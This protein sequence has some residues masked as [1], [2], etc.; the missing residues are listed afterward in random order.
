MTTK[1]WMHRGAALLAL[2]AAAIAQAA[3]TVGT[4]FPA[5]FPVIEDA[6][7]GKPVIGFGAAGAVTR[8]PVIF[9]HGNNDVPYATPCSATN[10]ES[11]IGLYSHNGAS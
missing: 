10:V 1:T 7:L 5:D 9:L 6:S 8:T 11:T 3:G 2:L 4:T